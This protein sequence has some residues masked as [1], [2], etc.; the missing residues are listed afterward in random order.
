MNEQI[1]YKA[2]YIIKW[3]RC[4]TYIAIVSIVNSFTNFLSFMPAAL[5][6]WIS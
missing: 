4:L 5:S 6:T 2:E 3:L 1:E